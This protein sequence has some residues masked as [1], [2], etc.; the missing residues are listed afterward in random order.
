M[1][2]EINKDSMINDIILT[3]SL[4]LSTIIVETLIYFIGILDK[5]IIFFISNFIGIKLIYNVLSK[6]VREY[7]KR[8]RE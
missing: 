8:I 1:K 7:R 4:V 6:I 5:T 3:I 2:H